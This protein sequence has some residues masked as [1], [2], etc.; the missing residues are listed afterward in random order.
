MIHEFYYIISL[1]V[2]KF[3]FFLQS[4][5]NVRRFQAIYVFGVRITK[6]Y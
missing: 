4:H 6:S 2:W 1:T 3:K 5:G